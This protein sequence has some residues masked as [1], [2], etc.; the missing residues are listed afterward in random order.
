MRRGRWSPGGVA[1]TLLLAWLVAYPILIVAAEAANGTAVRDFVTRPGEWHA[2]WASIWISVAS[3][4]LAAAAGVPL[5]F[6]FEGFDFPGRRVSAPWWHCQRSCR[7][8]S[9]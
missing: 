9:A 4:G 5:A 2:L 6:L 3:V 1:L 8:S 7:R